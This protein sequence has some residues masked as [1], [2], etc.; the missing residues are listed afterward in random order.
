MPGDL[1]ID[2]AKADQAAADERCLGGVKAADGTAIFRI[3]DRV[4]DL[5]VMLTW[6]H[7]IGQGI[8]RTHRAVHNRYMPKPQRRSV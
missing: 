7:D 2:C 3:E 1:V 8:K 4:S 5:V 6:P